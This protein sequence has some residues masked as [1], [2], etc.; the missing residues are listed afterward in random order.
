MTGHV[1][2]AWPE[3]RLTYANALVVEALLDLAALVDVRDRLCEALEL[4]HWLV[5]HETGPGGDFSFTPVGGRGP[6]E[7][8]GF[9]QQPIEAWCMAAACAR[10]AGLT[11]NPVWTGVCGRAISWF[12]GVNDQRARM[13]DPVTGA[14]FDG[15]TQDGVNLNQGT[16]STLALIGTVHA[17]EIASQ[18]F[19]PAAMRSMR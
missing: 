12:D 7:P 19:P 6:G 1:G 8:S 11:G 13:W 3:P 14:A 15:L 18:S 2:W 17:L 4:L 10:A 5:A 16:E 9:D